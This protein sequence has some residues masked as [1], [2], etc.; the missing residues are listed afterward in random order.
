[1]M[2]DPNKHRVI[3]DLSGHVRQRLDQ[4]L[5][6]PEWQ[7][8]G[9][10]PP[11]AALAELFD[12]SRPTLRKA[13]KD[14]REEGRVL[15][16]RGSG[17]FVQPMAVVTVPEHAWSDLT[18]RTSFD[19]KRCLAFRTTIECAAAAL[20]ATEA[21]QAAIFNLRLANAELNSAERVGNVFDADFAFHMA[22][23][24]A[25]LNP[26]FP[27]VLQTIKDQIRLTIQFTRQIS[28]TPID[29]IEPRV[30]AEHGHIV[31]AIEA[32][33][34]ERARLAMDS[35]MRETYVRLMGRQ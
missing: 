23:A 32:K 11:E 3:P 35:H 18:I 6:S 27:F 12:V 10:L 2:S 15:S 4:W 34:A 29:M 19:M 8:G 7:Q 5:S 33:D 28:N 25:T 14:L 30:I 24:H 20:A 13:L 9:R 26:Y 17:N 31:D 22:V 1:M 16:R 21:D